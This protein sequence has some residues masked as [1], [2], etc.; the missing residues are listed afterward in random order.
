MVYLFLTTG[1]ETIEAL[2]VVDLFRR[3]KL[4]IT[5]VSI[6]SSKS[7]TS[8]LGITVEADALFEECNFSDL[9]ALVLPG[10]P[11]HMSLY[12]YEPL[13]TLILQ[14]HESKKIIGAICAAPIILETLGIHVESTIFPSMTD[15]LTHYVDQDVWKDGHIITG[16]AMGASIPFALTLINEIATNEIATQVS[17]SIVYDWK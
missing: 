5:T 14:V 7:V 2:T 13:R 8:S 15:Q 17:Q 1:H 9:D 12:E 4:P 10:G 11:G 16:R 6:T 3:A